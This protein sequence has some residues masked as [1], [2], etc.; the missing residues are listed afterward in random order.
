MP[1]AFCYSPVFS[2]RGM[3]V[4]AAGF[5][6]SFLCFTLH[7]FRSLL[8]GVHLPQC[9]ECANTFHF[10]C[11]FSPPLTA[12]PR[13][14]RGFQKRQSLLFFL[15]VTLYQLFRFFIDPRPPLRLNSRARLRVVAQPRFPSPLQVD[16]FS[17]SFYPCRAI[18]SFLVYFSPSPLVAILYFRSLL[19]RDDGVLA[20]RMLRPPFLFHPRFSTFYPPYSQLPRVHACSFSPFPVC[21]HRLLSQWVF[22][23]QVFF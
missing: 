3:A 17:I 4:S 18:Q 20:F 21:V 23:V 22:G 5:R 13:R 14:F 19:N 2:T 6:P 8:I 16:L 10:I 15:F 11:R 1:F 12:F 9:G 7:R